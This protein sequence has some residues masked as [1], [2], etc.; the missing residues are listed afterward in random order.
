MRDFSLDAKLIAAISND[1]FVLY[2]LDNGAE[3]RRFKAAPIK[4]AWVIR[5]SPDGKLAMLQGD[6]ADNNTVSLLVD[7]AD[8]S[9]KQR[10]DEAGGAKKDDN[11]AYLASISDGAFSADGKRLA[12]GHF[13]GTAD[14]WDVAALKRISQLPAGKDDP[15]QIWSL[16]FSRDGRKLLSC[17]RD[18]GAYLWALDTGKAPRAFLYDDYAAMH[19]HLGSAALSHD[20]ATVAAGSAQ[21]AV[22]SGDTGLER[23][24][25]LWNAATGK[26]R[27]SWRG[28]ERAVNAVAFS[29]DDRMTVSASRDG[30]IKYWETQSGKE[31]ATILVANDGRW[32]VVSPSGLFAGNVAETNLFGFAR[33]LNARPASD[34]KEQLYKP[35]LIAE[36]LK[37]DPNHRYAAAAKQLDLKKT[38]DSAAP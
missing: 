14:I 4:T 31:I 38:W 36:L 8:G 28:H 10:F 3:I 21:H 6:D 15:G 35:D 25:K 23:S 34:F 16:S 20:G 22:S 7:T 9:V 27:M 29:A 19:A 13:N 32:A 18:G 33:G 37:G 1:S 17:S 12:L 30:T 24:V 2:S 5:L 11:A 26:L